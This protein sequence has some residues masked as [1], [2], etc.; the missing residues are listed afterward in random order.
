M[1]LTQLQR[2]QFRSQGF[3]ENEIDGLNAAFES[4]GFDAWNAELDRLRPIAGQRVAAVNAAFNEGGL[5]SATRVAEGYD[6][7]TGEEIVTNVSTTGEEIVTTVPKKKPFE[8]VYS[9]GILAG[10]S[11]TQIDALRNAYNG[12]GSDIQASS[13]AVDAMLKNQ[14]FINLGSK[15][16]TVTVEDDR[17]A[18]TG[19]SQ[20]ADYYGADDQYGWEAGVKSGQVNRYDNGGSWFYRTGNGRVLGEVS[21]TTTQEQRLKAVQGLSSDT[22]DGILAASAASAAKAKAAA[23]AASAASS[24][25]QDKPLWDYRETNK[26]PTPSTPTPSPPGPSIPAGGFAPGG[27]AVAASAFV[28]AV[29][30][31]QAA[32]PVGTEVATPGGQP[33]DV[34]KDPVVAGPVIKHDT[35]LPGDP[36][37]V[38][39]PEESP[40]VLADPTPTSVTP[41][42]KTSSPFGNL[43]IPDPT[44]TPVTPAE[45]TSNP[46]GSLVMPKAPILDFIPS[47]LTPTTDVKSEISDVKKKPGLGI[48]GSQGGSPPP[49]NFSYEN[50]V[51]DDF[52]KTNRTSPVFGGGPGGLGGF[53]HP[54][55]SGTGQ[56]R[57]AGKSIAHDN[58]YVSQEDKRKRRNRV[59]GFVQI[60]GESEEETKARFEAFAYDFNRRLDATPQ[61]KADLS[62]PRNAAVVERMKR[63]EE[64]K[65]RMKKEYPDGEPTVG[66]IMP[67]GGSGKLVNR[68]GQE[69]GDPRSLPDYYGNESRD[70]RLPQEEAEGNQMTETAK[71]VRD[72]QLRGGTLDTASLQGLTVPGQQE[73]QQGATAAAAQFPGAEGTNALRGD[74]PSQ[75]IAP[76]AESGRQV[77]GQT[78]PTQTFGRDPRSGLET[79]ISNAT[80]QLGFDIEKQQ[81]A[82]QDR[83]NT[84]FDERKVELARMLQVS[85]PGGQDIGTSGESQRQFEALAT[86]RANALSQNAIESGARLR[87]EQRANIGTFQGTAESREQA[88][89]AAQQA[90]LASRGQNIDYLG[91]KDQTALQNRAQQ[92]QEE[93]GRRQLDLQGA[94]LFGGSAG[95]SL[96]GAGLGQP[97]STMDGP[98]GRIA[99]MEQYAQAFSQS[100][101]RMPTQEEINTVFAGGSAGGRDTA[102][103]SQFGQQFTEAQARANREFTQSQAEFNRQSN[104]QQ[105]ELFGGT[106]G[107]SFA[108]AGVDTST[109]DVPQQIEKFTEAFN[110]SMGRNPTQDEIQKAYAGERVGGSKT[111]QSSQFG[112]QFEEQQT[113]ANRRFTKEELESNREFAQAQLEQNRQFGQSQAEFDR[114][115]SL[116]QAELFGGTR[117]ITLA[118]AGVDINT[119][120]P[121]QQVETFS[122]AFF[123]V[124]GRPPTQDDV[125]RAYAGE[126]VGGTQTS[127]SSQFGQQFGQQK[128]ESDREFEQAKTA[129]N[130]QFEQAKTEQD[131]Q[132][133]QSKIEQDRQFGFM[134]S[135]ADR[136]NALQRRNLENQTSEI[137][138]STQALS[139]A[140]VGTGFSVGEEGRQAQFEAFANTFNDRF[141][142][143]P[144]QVEVNDAYAGKAVGA[145]DTLG[146]IASG[147]TQ[148][149]ID[150][151]SQQIRNTQMN[152][153]RTL[154]QQEAALYGSQGGVT[155]NSLGIPNPQ[156][157]PNGV[158]ESFESQ[159]GRKPSA[160][161]FVG[162]MNGESVGGQKTLQE[163]DQT[164]RQ[165]MTKVSETG[166]ITDPVTGRRVQTLA[167]RAQSLNNSSFNQSVR[168][169]NAEF[170]QDAIDPKTGK[171]RDSEQVRQFNSQLAQA[172]QRQDADIAQ[173][174]SSITG[175][176]G[177]G[178]ISASDLGVDTDALKDVPPDYLKRTSEYADLGDRFFEQTGIRA[179]D[180]QMTN[181]IN[182]DT[183]ESQGAMTQ[184]A[185]QFASAVTQQNLDRAVSYKQIASAEGI[186]QAQLQQ[187]D[188]QN[189]RDWARVTLDVAQQ[190]G[191][192]PQDWQKAVMSMEHD[193]SANPNKTREALISDA[194]EKNPGVDPI[195]FNRGMDLY[196][197]DYGNAKAQQAAA[198]GMQEDQFARTID[199][200]T[201]QESREN[202]TWNGLLGTT[203]LQL[204]QNRI[205]ND[206][207]VEAGGGNI[208]DLAS[209]AFGGIEQ[210]LKNNGL[211]IGKN[212]GG[213]VRMASP[214]QLSQ[215]D[216]NPEDIVLK[217]DLNIIGSSQMSRVE[218]TIGELRQDEMFSGVDFSSITDGVASSAGLPPDFF[219][220]ATDDQIRTRVESLYNTTLDQEQID[221]IRSGDQS[222][223][224][225]P[226]P[227]DFLDRFEDPEQLNAIMGWVAG[228]SPFTQDQGIWGAIGQFAGTAAV[229]GASAYAGRPPA[230][231]T[232]Q[233]G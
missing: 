134:G 149:Q 114:Q 157:D 161:E 21:K 156:N 55:A 105:A 140:D 136:Q 96:A 104:L 207:N 201:R 160:Q 11:E 154:G 223:T 108:D 152:A 176:T 61:V 171:T 19:A 33:V 87:A 188:D 169:F 193:K 56:P 69:F 24:Q 190:V 66:F 15:T 231:P 48:K 1:A 118:D 232:P 65:A 42:E 97:S 5:Q 124:T 27:G 125:N 158:M 117:G 98:D 191:L 121:A 132:F 76:F 126:A 82:E 75:L 225:Q 198:L 4:G 41:A 77:F 49:S 81:A 233:K 224:I 119:M 89:L 37:S 51:P 95:L 54:G 20:Y 177:P 218:K 47:N 102:Q 46:F 92:F 155:S 101:G 79:N 167:G 103:S 209:T 44:P 39:T 164:F 130:R 163:R 221:S 67:P 168:E 9:G 217:F 28:P 230:P 62:D 212:G 144:S 116:Q 86:G 123:Q 18:E 150:Q 99:Q 23:S 179:T 222:V 204:D 173:Q 35:I 50:A 63:D 115:A 182:G 194:L 162:L 110:Q 153:V 7:T 143:M 226:A 228:V 31:D 196:D 205:I 195:A 38:A 32:D 22:M 111:A 127:Q 78:D 139:L 34:A 208:Q 129:Q 141:G 142:R 14:G 36:S 229:A 90:A 138:G 199:A 26:T 187:I 175:S 197:R 100:M 128:I 133:E 206:I 60:E 74:V 59:P 72:R 73:L 53:E 64:L 180:E 165:E 88:A 70:P 147:Q 25:G 137:F 220:N 166:F 45:K 12:A 107:I 112:Q 94:E 83:I 145:R 181:L 151:A 57:A 58:E 214:G 189:D 178:E 184:Q 122:K 183:I 29:T 71:A 211:R 120:D 215:Q 170:F 172:I 185:R 146:G 80:S 40:L 109:M 203:P 52:K 159:F 2:D 174:W 192:E 85:D 8:E 213:R 186:S 17:V 93:S 16:E 148:Q 113:E 3:V 219:E 43:T 10:L 68:D 227:R 202:S 6:P 216:L 30:G 131:R 135:E 210:H 13:N 106:Q 200:M 84:L 91:Q